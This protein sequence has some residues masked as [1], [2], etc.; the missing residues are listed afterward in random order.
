MAPLNNVVKRI[1]P[2]PVRVAAVGFGNQPA[3][4]RF[5]STRPD[6]TPHFHKPGAYYCGR[7][8]QHVRI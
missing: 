5:F 4:S 1:Q 6:V 8:M 7:C 3:G 2:E